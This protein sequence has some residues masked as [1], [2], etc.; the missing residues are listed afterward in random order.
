MRSGLHNDQLLNI[1]FIN[2]GSQTD[3]QVRST[4]KA[5]VFLSR[6]PGRDFVT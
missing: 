5:L 1:V 4:Q 6:C 2:R 3:I